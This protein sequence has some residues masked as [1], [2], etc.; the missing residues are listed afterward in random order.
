L[1]YE[2]R[3]AVHDGQGGDKK[4]VNGI[5]FWSDGDPPRRYK[6]LGSITDRRMETGIYGM[7]RMS[8][9]EFDVAKAAA[10][11]GGNAVIL[12]RE[13]E[14]LLGVSGFNSAYATGN[15]YRATGFGSSIRAPV[16]AHLARYIVVQYLPDDPG[17]AQ[18]KHSLPAGAQAPAQGAAVPAP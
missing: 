16:K 18:A 13:G 17:G 7:I 6:V 11:V 14:D 8:G 10:T 1:T 4:T 15:E 9:L 2:G 12:E 5:D 3:N